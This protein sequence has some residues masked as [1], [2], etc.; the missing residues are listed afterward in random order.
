MIIPR[1][2]AVTVPA[3]FLDM[4]ARLVPQPRP[5]STICSGPQALLQFLVNLVD[6]PL[7]TIQKLSGSGKILWRDSGGDLAAQKSA[8]TEA[9]NTDRRS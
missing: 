7:D 8:F 6:K 1:P 3:E 9:P 5:G 4:A 2:Q